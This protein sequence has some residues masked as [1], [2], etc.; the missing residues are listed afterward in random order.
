MEPLDLTFVEGTVARVGTGKEKVLEILQALQGHYGYLP[1]EAL[2]RVCELTEIVPASIAGVSTFYDQFRHRPAGRHIIHVCVGTAC[3]VK[4]AEQVLEEFRRYLE[5]PAGEDTDAQRLFT[6]ERIACLGCCTLAPAVQIDEITYGHLTRESVPKVLK[7]FLKHVEAR[8]AQRKMLGRR[9]PRQTGSRG[10]LRVGLGSCCQARGSGRLHDALLEAL[11]QTGTKVPVKRVGCV[12]MCH[13]TPLLEVVLP[14]QRSFL[15]ARVEPQDAKGI[16]LRHFGVKWPHKIVSN[17]V[18]GALDRLLTDEK[19]EPVTRYS[20]HVRDQAVSD[21]LGRQIHIATEHCGYI[22]PTDLD[23]YVR[24]D[25]FQGLE[26]VL[27]ELTPEAAIAQI[28]GSGLRGRGGAGFPT[29]LKWSAVRAENSDKK[30]I[31]CNGDEGDPG[32]FMDRMLMESYPYRILE[33]MIVAARCVGANEGFLYIRAEYPLAIKRVTEALEKCREK[34]FLGEHILGTDFS[35]ELKIVAGAGAFVC[36][37]ETALMASIEGR[38]GMPR[39]RPPFPAQKGLW[40]RPTLINN[41]ETYACVPWIIRNGAEAFARIG[42]GQSKGTKVFAL[43]GK[44]ARGGLI[45][46]PMGISVRQVVEEIG[47][48]IAGGLK[49]KAVQ[50][51]GPSGGCIPAARDNLSVD[52]ETLIEA[53][54]MMGSG[55][56]VVL[57][58]TDCMVDIARYFLQFTQNQSCGKCTFCRIGTRRML[59]ILERL[60]LGKGETADL[61]ELEHLATMIKKGS[62]CGLGK[63]AP[64]PV[65]TTLRYFREEYEAHVA[66]RCPAGKCKALIKYLVTDDCIGC[67]IC[68]QHC[69]ADAIAMKPYA[70]HEIDLEKCTR[71][72]T[73]K[74]VCPANAVRVE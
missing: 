43:A 12:G 38:R 2:Q 37:E 33:G 68:A 17:A 44:V 41:V 64:N 25:G 67:T 54:A 57:D 21:F 40:D 49:F 10:E 71:C 74:T 23:E 14:D 13:Q 55:G 45:E 46:V 16:V 73:C 31:V 27:R 5:I 65:L 8:A 35:L 20:I 59:D 69:P 15:Y 63:T 18:S 72:G 4:G 28:Q 9:R 6:V 22:D 70:K 61:A 51:G 3:H 58:E 60:C 47:G 29:H 32:A 50:V 34:G 56:L 53:G 7:D 11:A 24:H 30:Y 62:L 39:L 19:W 52:Y 42:V 66:G 36:G 1:N 26:K 48:G